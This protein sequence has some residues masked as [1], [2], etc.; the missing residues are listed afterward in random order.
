M[1]TCFIVGTDRFVLLVFG[2]HGN[3]SSTEVWVFRRW[4]FVG[5]TLALD[6]ILSLR[7]PLS[8]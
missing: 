2:C 3:P 5:T 4:L 8:P 7:G 1:K 6:F